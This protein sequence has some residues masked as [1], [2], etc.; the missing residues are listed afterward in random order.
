MSKR[1][2]LDVDASKNKEVERNMEIASS[3]GAIAVRLGLKLQ[4]A[5]SWEHC[6]SLAQKY[7]LP[8][9]ADAR[10]HDT[11]QNVVSVIESLSKLEYPPAAIT[12]HVFCGQQAMEQAQEKANKIHILGITVLNMPEF[13]KC[14]NFYG[15][16]LV[17]LSERLAEMAA[18]ANLDGVMVSARQSRRLRSMPATRNLLT[19]VYNTSSTTENAKNNKEKVSHTQAIRDGASFLLIG[20]HVMQATNPVSAYNELAA[21]IK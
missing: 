2:V 6:S 3:T 8:W 4:S 10:L 11:A 16:R 9:L 15:Q 13:A 19:L 1:I 18:Q 21:K 5:S 7:N 12:M 17:H 14:T 20:R